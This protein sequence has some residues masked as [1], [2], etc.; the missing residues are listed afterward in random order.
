M[1]FVFWGA[2]HGFGLVVE[3]E[4]RER[5]S[6]ALG[7]AAPVIGWVMTFHVVC[8]AWIFFR[9]ETFS[10]AWELI[11]RMFT[12]WGDSPGI[13]PLLLLVIAGSV[14]VQFVPSD[15]SQRFQIS[16]SRL[17]P[18]AQAATLAVGLVAIDTLGPEGVAPFIY[19]RF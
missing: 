2:I 19:F 4:L 12:A 3:R 7:R 8:L 17:A 5:F 10:T 14:A 11:G 1:T 16:F 6:G 13:S 18:M 9:A 15:L